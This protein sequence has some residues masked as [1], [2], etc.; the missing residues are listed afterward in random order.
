[1]V[2]LYYGYETGWMRRNADKILIQWLK[3]FGIVTVVL[4]LISPFKTMYTHVKG[5]LY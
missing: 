3:C 5:I 4:T 1:M 2:S